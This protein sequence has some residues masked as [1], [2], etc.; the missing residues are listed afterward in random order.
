MDELLK[1]T[2]LWLLQNT[3][4][5]LHGNMDAIEATLKERNKLVKRLVNY[6]HGDY[7]CEECELADECIWPERCIADEE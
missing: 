5:K 1:E 4:L 6:P 3:T 2:V 7:S